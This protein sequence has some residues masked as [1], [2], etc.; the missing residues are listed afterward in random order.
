M[1]GYVAQYEVAAG[2]ALDA[3]N[4]EIALQWLAI[5]DPRAGRLD[6][7]QLATADR[8]DA[9]QIKWSEAGGQMPWGELRSNIEDLV[10]D[11]QRLVE[12]H[13]DRQVFAHLGT[14]QVA[15]NTAGLAGAPDEHKKLSPADAVARFF[16]PAA[17][18]RYSDL[19]SV[20]AEWQ[21]LVES[22]AAACGGLG[23]TELLAA[24]TFVRLE[25]G[26]ILPT[27]RA[28]AASD[29]ASYE[30]DVL[31]VRSTLQNL[32][33]D[34]T[35]P[36]QI[37]RENFIDRL[38]GNWR[39]RLELTAVH[40]FPLPQSYV[41][42]RESAAA[43]QQALDEHSG[44]YL[45]LIGPPGSG[46][47]TLLTEELAK[48]KGVVARYYAY[49]PRRTEVGA[50]RFE[51]SSF[52][53]DLVLTLERRDVPLGPA[54]VDFELGPLVRRFNDELKRL[55]GRFA[56]KGEQA[57]ILVDGLDHVQRGTP[58]TPFL[59][60]LPTPDQLP[61]GV[62]FVL[63]TQNL[64]MLDA[65]I[66]GQLRDPGRTVQI[67]GLDQAAI[68]TI[69]ADAGVSVSPEQLLAVTGGHPL[70]LDYVLG[71]LTEL[72]PEDQ[73][74]HLVQMPAYEGDVRRLYE[75][76]WDPIEE[77]AGLVELLALVCR[78]RGA[79]DLGWLLDRGQDPELV[80]ALR[81][82]FYHLFRRE[83]G[84]WHF[85][86]ESFRLFLQ[87]RTTADPLEQE[88]D[89]QENRRYHQRLAEMCQVTPAGHPMR[90]ELLFHR[91][92]AA[93]H[94]EVLDLANPQ[95][96]REQH[97]ALRPDGLVAADIRLAARSLAVEQDPM[98]L[99]RLT[100]AAAE[101]TQ[102]SYHQPERERFLELLIATGQWQVVV[103]L[104]DVDRDEFGR[105][106]AR[107]LPL[108]IGLTLWHESQTEVARRILL[109]NEPLDLLTGSVD[110]RLREPYQLLYAWARLA[111]LV[112][113]PQALLERAESIDL[114]G[115][116]RWGPGSEDP[117]P[118]ARAWML[119][120]ASSAAFQA[121]H[122]DDAQTLLEQFDPSEPVQRDA[123]VWCQLQQATAA[124][125]LTEQV[126]A[127][128]SAQVNPEQLDRSQRVEIAQRHFHR[129]RDAARRWIEGVTQ[130]PL[131]EA[132]VHDVWEGEGT[133]YSLNRLLAALGQEVN[134][135]EVVP[136]A[137]S[138]FRWAYVFTARL[139][140]GVAQLE[141]RA[142]AGR[143]LDAEAF[144][145][146]ARRLLAT[147]DLRGPD[148]M[149]RGILNQVRG[150]VVGALMRAAVRHG[151]ECAESLWEFLREGWQQ[152]PRLVL[153]EA[154][155]VLP[156]VLEG[157]AAL[158]PAVREA[159]GYFVEQI[160]NLTEPQEL[161]R[162]LTEAADTALIIGEAQL[163][164]ALL[165]EAMGSTLTVYSEKDYQVSG[166]IKLLDP[167]LDQADEGPQLRDWLAGALVDL[168]RDAGTSQASDAA[169]QLVLG[170][171]RRRPG[172]AW[173]IG[174]WLEEHDVIA[175]DERMLGMLNATSDQAAH[176]GWWVTLI[177]GTLPTTLETPSWG[178][179]EPTEKTKAA[180]GK[181]WV[182]K[183]LKDLSA[184]LDIEAAP[185]IREDWR[186]L[187]AD[188]AV[189][190]DIELAD[191]DLDP[192]L[193]PSRRPARS[194]M[195]GTDEEKHDQYL[196][197]H[198]SVEAV[199]QALRDGDHK[200]RSS[201]WSEAL[202]RVASELTA[203]Q[204]DQI[205]DLLE[206]QSTEDLLTLGTQGKA[207]GTRE[208][209]ERLFE[210]I[211][212]LAPA[213]SWRRGYD[214]GILLRAFEHLAQL[215]Q[216]VTR[217]RAYRRLAADAST[218]RF[219]LGAMADDLPVYLDL[220]GIDDRDALAVEIE[221]YVR[222]LL[223]D[224][225]RLPPEDSDA[226]DEATVPAVWARCL[227]DLLNSPYRLAVVSAQRANVAALH[228][229]HSEMW[230]ALLGCLTADDESQV[231]ALSV[232]EAFVCSDGKLTDGALS[233]L[234][235]LALS[236][237]L[238]VRLAAARLLGTQDKPVP[239]PPATDLPASFELVTV[240]AKEPSVSSLPAMLGR[241]D[242][243]SS[244]AAAADNLVDLAKVTG[245]DQGVLDAYTANL[246]RQLAGNQPVDD[247]R[248]ETA[249]GSL[250]WTFHK[251]SILL[252]EHAAARL[253]SRI[254][255]ARLMEP[256]AAEFLT[257]GAM[258]DPCLIVHRPAARP[259]E[260]A[261]FPEP[262]GGQWSVDDQWLDGLTSAE[263][264]VIR[265]CKDWL[266]IGE[267]S[268]TRYLSRHMP[269]ERRWQCL[270]GTQDPLNPRPDLLGRRSLAEA[271]TG[272][273]F[274]RA[275]KLV[276]GHQDYSYR[277]AS[278]WL[279][280]NPRLARACGWCPVT[281]EAA[282]FEDDDG[283]LLR[284][285]WWRRGWIDSSQSL[286]DAEVGEGWLVL[287]HPR[288]LARMT[289][290]VGQELA[291]DWKVSRDFIAQSSGGEEA[292]Q[293]RRRLDSS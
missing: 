90:W 236:E 217:Q 98:A 62:V 197:D 60:F 268:D 38:G 256:A 83:A 249:Y 121:G 221:A 244:T 264:R 25:F 97:L 94:R 141:G 104:L 207:L 290:V 41:P 81:S 102:R 17:A 84:R 113:G 59:S 85:F 19:E 289:E 116:D 255:D 183:R 132:G 266:V 230:D 145:G 260:I 28:L 51:A 240:K 32:A 148:R 125:E 195:R 175:R 152:T 71:E 13:P 126:L 154:R 4:G 274:P 158:G 181:D 193:H 124:P 162:S 170:E 54:P 20:P 24:L 219:L 210:R 182:S 168:K 200:T 69:A 194:R 138:D 109:T 273:A 208:L 64:E 139:T 192:V 134:P 213:G 52:L 211:V 201:E 254:A 146:E 107:T 74:I 44:G 212:E 227:V 185:T 76:A 128:I 280:L 234:P 137:D 73:E 118:S 110:G 172:A 202:E 140:I 238:V 9:Y 115:I 22:L 271:R 37:E 130:P 286:H 23:P 291:V 8:L 293:G 284:S 10:R 86:H 258:W 46:K 164:A 144:M 239:E 96:F 179:V 292:R 265:R 173:R 288:A 178:L 108:R 58:Q 82:R 127:E 216:T 18:G 247:S 14:D 65:S 259:E 45:A 159:F 5:L 224:P 218:D 215:D 180:R 243:E 251:P 147:F 63:G 119:A 245:I 285:L 275:V 67:S 117:T 263:Q 190:A 47:S 30:R 49:V 43:L 235:E 15:S 66:R 56:D 75:R 150:G 196:R 205:A 222:Q 214:R 143:A 287:A 68:A 114:S 105:E 269:R 257:S 279:M 157:G 252:W 153:A 155:A 57:V 226:E 1:L 282:A 232:L 188:A 61:E 50:V 149:T 276:A 133:R 225:D 48:R 136:P 100:L 33:I 262:D 231:R 261:S 122:T 88:A 272:E 184:R 2:L 163:T 166:W 199:I 209:A 135:V 87:E 72:P 167:A 29:L 187:A 93:E 123:W 112:R 206:W 77:N 34:A 6:D 131:S 91:A 80:R 165:Q 39:D 267:I 160:R 31:H 228:E 95:F 12:H 174:R 21:W 16:T 277:S 189:G 281:G 3:L 237:N 283:T 248:F 70:L 92:A 120:S 142:V 26:Q 151:S 198:T 79:I 111:V 7:F 233:A 241:D 53:H 103:D 42:I 101:L 78:I 270:V 11:R 278:Q 242:L 106:D 220:F 27:K 253:G 204:I 169:E 229:G 223:R 36:V 55:G 161:A 186:L 191:V 99:V 250:G 129:D 89:E 171:A 246:A 177:E 176:G 156:I 40:E 203:E 35:R